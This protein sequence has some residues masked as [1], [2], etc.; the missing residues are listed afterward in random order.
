MSEISKSNIVNATQLTS[1]PDFRQLVRD[2]ER[3]TRR[4][5]TNAAS[6]VA[7]AAPQEAQASIQTFKT[8]GKEFQKLQGELA[9]LPDE[10]TPQQ[11]QQLEGLKQELISLQTRAGQELGLTR[12]EFSLLVSDLSK[13]SARL[14]EKH[15]ELAEAPDD[16]RKT[17]LASAAK[18][19]LLASMSVSPLAFAASE[20]EVEEAL[21]MATLTS[22]ESCL[23][24]CAVEHT[25]ALAAASGTYVAASAG[26]VGLLAAPVAGPFLAAACVGA[27]SVTY[28]AAGAAIIIA[29]AKCMA[30]CE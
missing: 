20:T 29:N 2:A 27:T 26:C 12:K 24:L 3:L 17:V 25:I 4:A 23:A 11:K 13:R 9:D 6:L 21:G 28:A 15:P 19:V 10:L 8:L 14:M 30:A 16:T 5:S 22:Q 18:P 1:D 7:A